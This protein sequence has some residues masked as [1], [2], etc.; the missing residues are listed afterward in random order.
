M[1]TFL[2]LIVIMVL[3]YFLL[4]G[5]FYY[6]GRRGEGE[7]I[8]HDIIWSLVSSIVFAASGAYL[9]EGKTEI[10]FDLQQH[11]HG[12]F[13]LSV[14]AF[15][16]IY[17]SYFYWTH[18]LLHH[19]KLIRWHMVHHNKKPTAWTSFAFHPLEAVLQALLVPVLVTFIPI[20]WAGLALFLGFISVTGVT[21]HLGYEIFPA[22]LEKK[23]N[24]ITANHH[25]F[26]H[27][28]LNRNFGLTF[29][30]WDKIMGTN[31]EK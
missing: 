10:Y 30:F 20:H 28:K 22:A 31:Y 13:V 14:C 26:H 9:I 16:L 29:T 18:R 2:F 17:D 15:V 23:F 12:Y 3:R 24:L 4:A 5:G 19:K 25:L 7:L 8:G 27:H 21:N 1:L 6:L 11:G